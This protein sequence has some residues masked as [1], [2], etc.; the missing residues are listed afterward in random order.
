[1]HVCEYF[2]IRTFPDRYAGVH[3]LIPFFITNYFI[4]TVLFNFIGEHLF[5]LNQLYLV[6]V[7]APHA[8]IEKETQ[9]RRQI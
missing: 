5:Q 8:F 4:S 9:I 3:S 1:M 7:G 2:V 6:G